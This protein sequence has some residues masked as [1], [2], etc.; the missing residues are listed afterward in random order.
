MS[1]RFVPKNGIAQKILDN[2]FRG[3]TQG[4]LTTRLLGLNQTERDLFGLYLD[5]SKTKHSI[6]E[7]ESQINNPVDEVRTHVP[8]EGFFVKRSR[9]KMGKKLTKE[10]DRLEVLESDARSTV[11]DSFDNKN[12]PYTL[13]L[14]ANDYSMRFENSDPIT[15]KPR[16]ILS[17]EVKTDWCNHWKMRLAKASQN[18]S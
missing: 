8:I 17:P 7:L 14:A 11:E 1:E 5:I 13:M 18:N 3:F 6:Y 15:K 4:E 12:V 16:E 10:R 2:P 9:T